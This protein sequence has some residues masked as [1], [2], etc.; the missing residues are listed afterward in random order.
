MKNR[1]VL[2][3]VLIVWV[4]FSVLYI[5]YTQYNYFTSYVAQSSY[6]KGIS[7]AVTQVLQQSQKCQPFPV[8]MG[9]NKVQL[10]NIDCLKQQAPAANGANK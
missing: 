1:P 2:K 6:E 9:N 8:N 7:D 4:V 10:I 3:I 5:G